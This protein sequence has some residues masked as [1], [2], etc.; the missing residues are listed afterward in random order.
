MKRIISILL[1]ITM[2]FIFASCGNKDNIL[3][4][5]ATK[6]VTTS[7]TYENILT[8]KE[9]VFVATIDDIYRNYSKYQTDYSFVK[10]EG[11]VLPQ[12]D[13]AG[14]TYKWVCRYGPGCCGSGGTPGFVVIFDCEMPDE[15]SWV[16]VTGTIQVASAGDPIYDY[17]KSILGTLY[18]DDTTAVSSY[19]YIKAE[20]VLKLQ[21]RGLETVYN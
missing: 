1:V 17:L 3:N 4:E 13:T 8:I 19:A 20:R 6:N 5:A 9:K 15:K 18:I 7:E 14:T 10:Y 16:E 12:T 21:T 2:L 11:F